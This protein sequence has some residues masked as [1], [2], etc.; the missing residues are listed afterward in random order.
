MAADRLATVKE[1]GGKPVCRTLGLAIKATLAEPSPTTHRMLRAAWFLGVALLPRRLAVR[2]IE[3]RFAVTRRPRRLERLVASL[4][5]NRYSAPTGHAGEMDRH[6]LP[7]A[8]ST[9]AE[10]RGRPP[11]PGQPTASLEQE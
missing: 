3:Y 1:P 9:A 8:G 2:L 5:G 11:R 4:L 6:R 10:S 7:A